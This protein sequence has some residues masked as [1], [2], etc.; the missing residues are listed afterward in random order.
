MT[1]F[2]DDCLVQGLQEERSTKEKQKPQ[3]GFKGKLI[4]GL[5]HVGLSTTIFLSEQIRPKTHI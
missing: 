2:L 5:G 1:Q 4:Q 3:E